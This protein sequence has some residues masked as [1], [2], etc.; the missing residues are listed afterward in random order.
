MA[1]AGVALGA[2]VTAGYA[3]HQHWQVVV[4]LSGVAGGVAAALALGAIAGLYPA[5]RAARLTPTDALRT[6]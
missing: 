6:P 2:L 5:I 1:P 3:T 4:P